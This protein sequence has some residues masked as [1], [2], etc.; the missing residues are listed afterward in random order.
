MHPMNKKKDGR[1]VLQNLSAGK[2]SIMDAVMTLGTNLP[3][4]IKMIANN[5]S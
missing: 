2:D 5:N 4:A 1:N 3:V